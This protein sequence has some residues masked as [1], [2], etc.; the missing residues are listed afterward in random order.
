M[1]CAFLNL[2]FPKDIAKNLNFVTINNMEN[3]APPCGQM[4]V[5]FDCTYCSFILKNIRELFFFKNVAS[6]FLC[7]FWQWLFKCDN[8]QYTI[9]P[10]RGKED[11][12]RAYHE[13]YEQVRTEICTF[14]L[15]V[16]SSNTHSILNKKC[17]SFHPCSYK[18][19][20]FHDHH[21]FV[22]L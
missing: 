4:I 19:N 17:Y 9:V 10:V 8:V 21:C 13:H 22:F 16:A 11:L 18:R 5:N 3:F 15:I 14:I 12:V 1:K 2:W 6:L 20:S 7:C